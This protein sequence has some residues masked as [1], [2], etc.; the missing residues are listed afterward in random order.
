MLKESACNVGDSTSI[1]GWEDTLEEEMASHSTIPAW[2]FPWTEEPGGGG[3]GGV[4]VYG[5][6]KSRTHLID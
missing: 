4:T 2:E 3:R 1:P 6:A 5:F